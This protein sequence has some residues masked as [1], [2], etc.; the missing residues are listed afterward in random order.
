[1]NLSAHHLLVK[2]KSM[3]PFKVA[4]LPHQ[5]A[6]LSLIRI[7]IRLGKARQKYIEISIVLLRTK[8]HQ[9]GPCVGLFANSAGMRN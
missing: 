3:H 8:H 1:M 9:D 7:R 2:L 4:L 6:C 5:S